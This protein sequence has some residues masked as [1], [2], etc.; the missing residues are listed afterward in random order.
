ML[1]A[2]APP[3]GAPTAEA[4]MA[5]AAT[6]NFSLS[7]WLLPRRVRSHLLALYGFARLVDELGDSGT[8]GQDGRVDDR[9]AALDWLERDLGRAYAGAAEHPLLVRLQPTLRECALPREPFVRLIEA[10]RLDQ[11]VSRYETWA[12][13]RGYCALSADPVGELVLGVFGLSTPARIALSDSICTALQLTEHC[14]DVA[15]DFARG[16]IYLPAEDLA[17]FGCT[18]ADLAGTRAGGPLRETLAFEVSRARVLFTAGA[19]LIEELPGRRASLAVAAFVAGGRA[20]LDA[21]ERAGY[22]VLAGPPR[23]PR[24]RR[25]L[26]LAA[27]LRRRSG[28]ASR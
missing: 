21:I 23:A 14:Q 12:Q 5:R 27:T 20:A 3:P 7:S 17:R 8:H 16:R 26:A 9:L 19:P 4:V 13:L 11:R 15:E 6:E 18:S 24:H 2:E 1:T 28:R 22:D 10:N 25:A